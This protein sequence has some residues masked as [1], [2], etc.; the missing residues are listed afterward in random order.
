MELIGH[1]LSRIVY[2]T[3]MVRS[4]GGA[5]LPEVAHG[6]VQKYSFLKFPNLEQLQGETHAFGMGK[7]QDFQIDELK[8]Y[9]DGIIVSAKCSTELLS[10]F[11]SDLFG[12]V[13]S[14]FGLRETKILEPEMYYESGLVVRAA[15]DLASVL[16]PPK[17]VSTVIEKALARQADYQPTG[18]SYE[19]DS[20][21]LKTRRRP[22]RF[23]VE[24]R[25]ALPFSTNVF[26]SIAPL[27]SV[28]HLSLLTT[29]EGLAD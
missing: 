14:E 7:F 18:I 22:V 28:D 20:E 11:V 17:R 21:G 24:R 4:G 3:N 13:R 29:L 10:E 5:Y 19:T 8:V 1:E 2:L 25:A 27:T 6:V 26:Y 16:S 23:A 9:G 12:W 15:K